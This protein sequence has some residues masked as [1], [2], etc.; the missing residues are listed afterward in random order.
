ME[1]LCYFI[2][3]KRGNLTN[4]NQFRIVI[5]YIG[6]DDLGVY[7]ILFIFS[8]ARISNLVCWSVTACLKLSIGS[9]SISHLFVSL[10]AVMVAIFSFM[11]VVL[12]RL[13]PDLFVFLSLFSLICHVT[14]VYFEVTCCLCLSNMRWLN[15]ILSDCNRSALVWKSSQ[16]A[17]GVSLDVTN[18]NFVLTTVR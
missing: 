1:R 16:R 5:L 7:S 10:K 8:E 18:V 11:I 4:A 6:L 14:V 2:W 13:L 15:L 12:S 9:F 17:Q 3:L